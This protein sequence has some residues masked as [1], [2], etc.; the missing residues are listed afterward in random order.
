MGKCDHYAACIVQAILLICRGFGK[1]EFAMKDSSS[2]VCNLSQKGSDT[3][4]QDNHPMYLYHLQAFVR[5]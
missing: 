4:R 3:L 5:A 2:N 1:F